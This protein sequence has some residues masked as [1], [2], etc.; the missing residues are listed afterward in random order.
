MRVSAGGLE[1]SVLGEARRVDPDWE[2]GWANTLFWRLVLQRNIDVMSCRKGRS[3]FFSLQRCQIP[4]IVSSIV[5][6]CTGSWNIGKLPHVEASLSI[7]IHLLITILIVLWTISFSR[8]CFSNIAV[9]TDTA[10]GV[11]I[12]EFCGFPN[13]DHDFPGK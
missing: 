11:C 4:F 5:I 7:A 12:K 10:F 8:V 3:V 2:R 6:R 9:I 13:F 1:P